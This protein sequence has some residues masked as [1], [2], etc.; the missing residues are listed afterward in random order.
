MPMLVSLT[1]SAAANGMAPPTLR[2]YCQQGRVVDA[3]RIGN[4]W[5]VPAGKLTILPPSRP[6]GR[7]WPSK[8]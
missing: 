2:G 5:A 1:E 6:P 8:G 3:Q 7:P 4:R